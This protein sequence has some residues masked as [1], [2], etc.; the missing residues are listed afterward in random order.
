MAEERL[1][2]H[3]RSDGTIG[4]MG[5]VIADYP[6]LA[7]ARAMIQVMADAGVAV[8]E[9]QIPFS[10]PMADGPVFLAANHKAL[11]RGVDYKRSLD[12]MREVS[13][14]HPD[15]DF[16]FMTY[17]NVVY[18]RGY[19]AFVREATEAGARGVI[20]PDLPFEY[21]GVLDAACKQY[22]FTNVPLIPP[23]CAG[24]RLAVLAARSEALVY[25]VARAGVTGAETHLGASIHGFLADLRR[26]TP[27]AIALGFG[28]RLP[29]HVRQLR[30]HADLAVVGTAALTAFE[31]GGLA[32]YRKFWME[33]AG[34]AF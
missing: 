3:R 15:V 18:K 32:A 8:V 9:V 5:H 14:R 20:L 19:A 6:T 23:N 26:R 25:A 30:G 17:V 1:K 24:E 7:D 12:L 2:S 16:V 28:I 21:A 27:A 22:S 4:L 29:D 10:E 13:A 33:L 34:A 31:D 11:A